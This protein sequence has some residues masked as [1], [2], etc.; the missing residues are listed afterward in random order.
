MAKIYTP[1]PA[2]PE[3][4]IDLFG[5]LRVSEP[6][7]IVKIDQSDST[8]NRTITEGV[9]SGTNTSSNYNTSDSSRILEVATNSNGL[10]RLKTRVCGSYQSGKSLLY[11]TTFSFLS[12]SGTISINLKSTSITSVEIT[13]DNWNI[14]KMDGTGVSGLNLDFTKAHIFFIALEWLGVGDIICGFVENRDYFPCHIFKHSNQLTSTYMKTANLFPNYEVENSSNVIK[15][16]IGYFDNSNGIQLT[17]TISSPTSNDVKLRAICAS[18]INE[19]SFDRL[20]CSYSINR[21]LGSS[22]TITNANNP[23]AVMLFRLNPNAINSR[24]S[25]SSIDINIVTNCNYIVYICRAITFS[26]TVTPSWTD[27]PDSSIQYDNNPNIASNISISNLST[28]N[29]YSFLGINTKQTL[30]NVS[31]FNFSSIDC[32]SSDH[33][34]TPETWAIVVESD[35]QNTVVS[36]LVVR[37]IED[38]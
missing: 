29:I 31:S 4:L 6:T 32:L 30:S 22:V 12:S 37:F 33:T 3:N 38:L 14:D 35:T 21:T 17:Q 16:R 13:R 5:R 1:S 7:I 18:L 19:G 36:S 15:K 27:L 2:I 11:L 25:L 9:V 34:Y 23:R 24:V 26:S 10:R 20:S 28:A 8:L